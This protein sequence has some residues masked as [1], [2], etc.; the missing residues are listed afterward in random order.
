MDGKMTINHEANTVGLA[1]IIQFPVTMKGIG[2]PETCPI[3]K[4]T[5]S[6]EETKSYDKFF[7]NEEKTEFEAIARDYPA[8]KEMLPPKNV[9]YRIVDKK[10]RASAR[11]KFKNARQR[12]KTELGMDVHEGEIHHP[13]PLVYGGCPVHQKM[14]KKT[15]EDNKRV[16]ERINTVFDKVNARYEVN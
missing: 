14:I 9:R 10:S 1:G 13:H 11:T 16:D 4:K 12:A 3:C 8:L 2:T 7:N 15:T 5:K 6:E